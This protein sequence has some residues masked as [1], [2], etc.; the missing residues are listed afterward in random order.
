MGFAGRGGLP[1]ITAEETVGVLFT[2]GLRME[3]LL[4]F[5]SLDVDANLGLSFIQSQSPKFLL[6]GLPI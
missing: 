3:E 4:N 1:S 2:Y 5:S 6:S